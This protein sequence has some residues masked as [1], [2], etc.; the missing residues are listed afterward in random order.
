M[1]NSLYQLDR[2]YSKLAH[3]NQRLLTLTKQDPVSL[4][5]ALGGFYVGE[6][7]ITT[8]RDLRGGST[9]W[10]VNQP[11]GKTMEFRVTDA[12][13]AVAYVQNIKIGAGDIWCVENG[14]SASVVATTSV[15]AWSESAVPVWTPEPSTAGEYKAFNT[16]NLEL[17]YQLP[18]A[19][20]RQPLSWPHPPL[21][22]LPH[23]PRLPPHLR[24][25]PQQT[26]R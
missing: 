14:A 19:L 22:P 13:G 12:K 5:I 11:A 26:H 25:H 6:T 8:L 17:M 9:T 3:L 16:N 7:P 10:L 24:N 1:W 2:S 18:V 20:A 15:A 21:L 4:F 23:P